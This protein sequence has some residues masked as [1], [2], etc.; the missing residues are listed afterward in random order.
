[1]KYRGRGNNVSSSLTLRGWSQVIPSWITPLIGLLPWFS[2]F[3]CPPTG[4]SGEHFLIN[5]FHTNPYLFICLWGTQYRQ[6]PLKI[7]QMIYVHFRGK[8]EMIKKLKKK[9]FT[10]YCPKLIIINIV[11]YI[12]FFLCVYIFLNF[13]NWPHI[14]TELLL[15]IFSPKSEAFF[16]TFSFLKVI[17]HRVPRDLLVVEKEMVL[18]WTCNP[19]PCCGHEPLLWGCVWHGSIS[20]LVSH[21]QENVNNSPH[22]ILLI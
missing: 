1:M 18:K 22:S 19:P 3:P 14:R 21:P 13:K 4:F 6:C 9:Y 12:L 2:S 10:S 17:N 11:V 5:L 7:I 20:N 16:L 8:I 15:V